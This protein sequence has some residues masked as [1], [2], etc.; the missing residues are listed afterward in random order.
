MLAFTLGLVIQSTPINVESP[1]IRLVNLIPK[2]AAEARL[3]LSVVPYLENDVVAIRTMGRPWGEV[4]ANLAKV[5]NATW[6]EKDGQFILT[7]TPEQQKQEKDVLRSI[8]LSEVTTRLAQIEEYYSPTPWTEQEFT[9]WF[10]SSRA[11]VSP[12][13][14]RNARNAELVKRSRSGETGRLIAR[15][16]HQ[17][18]PEMLIP[19]DL[20]W[21][22]HRYS[23]VPIQF[24]DRIAID[25]K[26]LSTAYSQEWEMVNS[27]REEPEVARSQ[28]AG[29]L[30]SLWSISRS[31]VVSVVVFDQQGQELKST[32]D[33]SRPFPVISE[34]TLRKKPELSQLFDDVDRGVVPD[35]TESDEEARAKLREHD[36]KEER[37]LE[38][39]GQA[40][41]LDP[42][43]LFGGDDWVQ[44]GK[45]KLRPV[46]SLLADSGAEVV[47]Q[48]SLP[49]LRG[50]YR[51]DQDGWIL[52]SQRD[53][54]HVRQSRADRRGIARLGKH[55]PSNNPTVDI[56]SKFT[57]AY[58]TI[59]SRIDRMRD[60]F[61]SQMF[62]D[63][64]LGNPTLCGL[65]GSL[66]PQEMA[67]L[68]N[69]KQLFISSLGDQTKGFFTKNVLLDS[70]LTT[71]I[72]SRIPIL[73]FPG[74][75][76]GFFLTA[77]RTALTGYTLQFKGKSSN[78]SY[79]ESM[80]YDELAVL[81]TAGKLGSVDHKVLP[82]DLQVANAERVV[83][84]LSLG[85]GAKQT[86]TREFSDWTTIDRFVP[87][88]TLGKKFFDDLLKR[89]E[90]LIR[91]NDGD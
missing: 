51:I 29:A 38:L 35:G 52:S 90:Q 17:V 1:G 61:Q 9:K 13:L 47:S 69:G 20:D 11:K 76:Q 36:L 41:T 74:L 60:L 2:L 62:A 12:E 86:T 89:G 70:G 64:G 28:P 7:Q 32:S 58:D 45:E 42:L 8:M 31:L 72:D 18:K 91:E 49:I 53:A 44:L 4:K 73:A 54:Y 19:T 39:L 33:I 65:F 59:L 63:S 71:E 40:E 75:H 5:L 55:R 22:G 37:L 21:D 30:F 79:K 34:E 24:H 66:S 16:F 80:D 27:R 82:E 46:V 43:A 6:E 77:K 25:F 67:T 78:D 87:V 88:K 26:P 84:N 10:D 85:R 83:L 48:D 50:P 68:L 56:L 57:V 23:T 15:L 81:F 14:S 3:A